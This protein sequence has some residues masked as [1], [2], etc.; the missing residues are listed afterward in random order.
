MFIRN[1]IKIWNNKK[2]NLTIYSGFVK[3]IVKKI[4]IYKYR[5]N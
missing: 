2:V 4:L 1:E 3:L 5:K